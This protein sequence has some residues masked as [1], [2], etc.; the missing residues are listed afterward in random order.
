MGFESLQHLILLIKEQDNRPDA[1]Q[2]QQEKNPFLTFQLHDHPQ[3]TGIVFM[4]SIIIGKSKHSV[5]A[6]GDI[7]KHFLLKPPFFPFF[8]HL[9]I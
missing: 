6:R 4:K 9:L 8:I 3:E 2:G 1:E 7:R 5:P